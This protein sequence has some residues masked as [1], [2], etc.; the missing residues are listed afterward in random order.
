MY[1]VLVEP[2]MLSESLQSRKSTIV[3]ADKPGTKCLEAKRA[4]IEGN[5]CGVPIK[6]AKMSAINNQQLLSSI[7][8]NLERR[9]MTTRS[10]NKK[11]RTTPGPH[12]DS[13]RL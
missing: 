4:A 7:T 2:S 10:S 13:R 5:F 12:R 1:D 11:A 3:Y 9:L 8:N 6:N